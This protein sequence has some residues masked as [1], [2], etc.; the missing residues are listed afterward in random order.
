MQISLGSS[1]RIAYFVYRECLICVY[2]TSRECMVLI[3][4]ALG[5]GIPKWQKKWVLFLYLFFHLKQQFKTDAS[6][7]NKFV[8][9]NTLKFCLNILI[10]WGTSKLSRTETKLCYLLVFYWSAEDWPWSPYCTGDG[11]YSKVLLP[12][13]LSH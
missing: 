1:S 12:C 11:S 7:T 9:S 10:Y 2:F 8:T 3:L 4:V 5:G 6:V 13:L